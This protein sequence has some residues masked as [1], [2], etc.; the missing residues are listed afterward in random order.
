MNARVKSGLMHSWSCGDQYRFYPGDG[1]EIPHLNFFPLMKRLCHLLALR[2]AFCSLHK[3]LTSCGDTHTPTFSLSFSSTALGSCFPPPSDIDIF[4]EQP[5]LRRCGVRQQG[6]RPLVQQ[7]RAERV[8]P[9]LYQLDLRVSGCSRSRWP[10]F[11]SGIYAKLENGSS[12]DGSHLFC[13]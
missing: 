2:F 11:F 10:P 9:G 12:L 8:D 1:P 13:S 4:S 3:I 6:D 7:E 5:R